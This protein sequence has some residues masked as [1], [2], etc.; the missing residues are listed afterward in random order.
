MYKPAGCQFAIPVGKLGG[1]NKPRFYARFLPKYKKF[2]DNE[3]V[4]YTYKPATPEQ[5]R[6]VN[7][8]LQPNKENVIA[9]RSKVVSKLH[10]T[11]SPGYTVIDAKK[12]IQCVTKVFVIIF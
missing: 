10:N 2:Y 11:T 3:C 6:K 1:Q 8:A 4:G 12:H 7:K 5:A 9:E